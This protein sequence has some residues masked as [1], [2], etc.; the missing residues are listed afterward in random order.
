MKE[1]KRCPFCGS[2]ELTRRPGSIENGMIEPPEITC[3]RCQICFTWGLAESL[4][5]VEYAWNQRAK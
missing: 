1:L 3:E 5:D 4:E 2:K